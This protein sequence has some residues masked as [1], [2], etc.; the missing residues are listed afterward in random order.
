MSLFKRLIL[1]FVAVIAF[2]GSFRLIDNYQ[3]DSARV[4]LSFEVNAPNEDDYQVFFLTVAEGGEWN[5]AQSKHLIYDKPGQWKKM[6]YELP[7]NTLK[8]R[9]DLGTQK[10]DI[11]IRNVQA[12]AISTQPIQVENININTNEVKIAQNQD[13]S[14][15]IESIGGDPYI[16]FNFTPIAST[17]FEGFSTLHI[18][19]NLLGSVLIA[20][21]TAFIVRHL[22]KSL[23]LIK[24][25]YQSRNLA[26][27]L[28]KNDFKTKF[29]SSYLGVVWGFITPL[30]TIVTYWFVFQVGLRSGD[31]AEVPFILWFIAGIIPWFFF[32]EAFS[33]AT[34]AFIEYSY[35]VK[36]VVFRIELLPFVKIGSALFVHLF[37]IL[38]IFIVYGVYG[39]YP[40]VY[41][42]QILYYLICTIFLVFSMS[43][44]S[45]SLVL[46]F[47]DLNQII[48]IV[49][50]MGFWFTPI[51]WPVT[52][53]NDFWAFIFKL[54][55][56][57][58]IVQGFRDSLIDH[59][60]FYER[61]YEMLY[62]WFFCF[63]VLTLG[64]LTFKKLK[65][66]FSDVL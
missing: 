38:F 25:I 30:L 32:S 48:G 61:P 12:K 33:G 15:R 28:A 9:I 8:V 59:V 50:Q 46:F 62:F 45:A 5:E 19:G 36:K 52:M 20:V 53:L 37:F 1:L 49:L 44:L 11:S 35:L 10:A 17:I 2:V 34:N 6:S 51:G 16:A 58:Y 40:T 66:H 21:L 24:P 54:N 47:K 14:L 56:M 57:F 64:V 43:L 18:V 39:Y 41:T 26:L 31:V 60:I 55:P 4:S 22:K 65:S 3:K 42:V 7:N 27:N 29:A 23:E 63:S 13:Q